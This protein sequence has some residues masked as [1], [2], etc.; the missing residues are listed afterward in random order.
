MPVNGLAK[1]LRWPARTWPALGLHDAGVISKHRMGEFEALC[2]LD[3]QEMPPRKTK[4]LREDARVS[5]AV[6]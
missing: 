5:Q 2:H 4:S 3:V 6:I 1:A